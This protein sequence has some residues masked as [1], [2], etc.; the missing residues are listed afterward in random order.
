MRGQIKLLP[1][2]LFVCAWMSLPVGD[3]HAGRF[4][5]LHS[6]LDGDD[7]ATSNAPVMLDRKGNIYGTALQGGTSNNGV[8][9]EVTAKGQESVLYSFAGGSDGRRPEAGLVIDKSG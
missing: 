5:M 4:H 9:F 1:F 6:F 8:V 7:G 3:A 2:G